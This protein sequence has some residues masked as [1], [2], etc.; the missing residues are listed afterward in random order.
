M[1]SVGSDACLANR[2]AA[3][4][5]KGDEAIGDENSAISPSSCC[6]HV[7]AAPV[8]LVVAVAFRS[9]PD[10]ECCALTKSDDAV[11]RTGM[12]PNMVVCLRMNRRTQ[13]ATQLSQC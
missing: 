6:C 11:S 2:A 8:V 9:L 4:I 5:A 7:S 12:D 1:G 13:G 3:L 10:R